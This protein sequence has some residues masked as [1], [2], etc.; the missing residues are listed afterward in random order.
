MK[1]TTN[2]LKI[3][4]RLVQLIRIG[5]YIRHKWVNI[6]LPASTGTRQINNYSKGK[7]ENYNNSH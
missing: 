7:G 5:K 1:N 4:N 2:D 6:F 3:G